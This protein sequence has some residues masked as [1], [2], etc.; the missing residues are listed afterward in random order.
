M[1]KTPQPPPPQHSTQL[2]HPT[3][4]RHLQT[5]HTIPPGDSSHIPK[6]L[7]VTTNQYPCQSPS[8]CARLSPIKHDRFYASLVYLSMLGQWKTLVYQNAWYF[9]TPFSCCPTLALFLHPYLRSPT[10]PR[11]NRT[12]APPSNPLS[13]IKRALEVSHRHS[14]CNRASQTRKPPMTPLHVTPK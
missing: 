10:H 4:P 8:K 9:P 7:Y 1:P 13:T 11:D 5:T 3:P 2:P 12:I 14:F 6:Y